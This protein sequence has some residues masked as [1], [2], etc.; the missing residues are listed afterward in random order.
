MAEVSAVF[1]AEYLLLLLLRFLLLR[2]LFSVQ[3]TQSA[4]KLFLLF[5]PALFDICS[6]CFY[7]YIFWHFTRWNPDFTAV[8]GYCYI[9]TSILNRYFTACEGSDIFCAVSCRKAHICCIIIVIYG[10]DHTYSVEVT[11]KCKLA[12]GKLKFYVASG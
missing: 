3:E 9:D 7:R 2:L 4:W 10:N 11:G 1:Q 6:F 8:C 12:V 5:L